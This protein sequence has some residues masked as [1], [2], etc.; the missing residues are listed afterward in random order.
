MDVES[1]WQQETDSD[2]ESPCSNDCS[3]GLMQYKIGALIEEKTRNKRRIKL[4]T[5]AIS[6][7]KDMMIEHDPCGVTI[8]VEEI[9]AYAFSNVSQHQIS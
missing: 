7:T 2:I 4:C 8:T 6:E 1:H 5:V 9:E 3:R